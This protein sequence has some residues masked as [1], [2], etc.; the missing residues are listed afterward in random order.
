MIC[1]KF[2]LLLSG[3]N[4]LGTFERGDHFNYMCSSF[5][6]CFKYKNVEFFQLFWKETKIYFR[7]FSCLLSFPSS[8][9][10]PAL[11]IIRRFWTQATDPEGESCPGRSQ[12]VFRHV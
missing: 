4:C 10:F 8:I 11:L 5:N 7:I 2:L 6:K 1:F 12:K 9:A 3:Q